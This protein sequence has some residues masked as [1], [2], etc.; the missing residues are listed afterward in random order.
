MYLGNT[1][2]LLLSYPVCL[3]LEVVICIL[4]YMKLYDMLHHKLPFRFIYKTASLYL[5]NFCLKMPPLSWK[6]YER[7]IYFI[8]SREP[9]RIVHVENIIRRQSS[10]T[11]QWIRSF[12]YGSHIIHTLMFKLWHSPF[13]FLKSCWIFGTVFISGIG[14]S[15][16]F[17]LIGLASL[18]LNNFT[19]IQAPILYHYHIVKGLINFLNEVHI[20]SFCALP[21]ICYF[22]EE[23]TCQNFEMR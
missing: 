7:F 6:S 23:W 8:S 13:Q 20:L 4:W 14:L 15:N 22:S 12:G 3:P 17:F 18:N 11:P 16:I 9:L 5:L 10:A 2:I 1:I 19:S 21:L